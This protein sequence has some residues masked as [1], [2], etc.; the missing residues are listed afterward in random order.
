MELSSSI[1]IIDYYFYIQV[2][3]LKCVIFKI[4]FY[5]CKICINFSL[6]FHTLWLVCPKREINIKGQNKV[7]FDS[8]Y[9]SLQKYRFISKAPVYKGATLLKPYF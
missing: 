5:V 4:F 8:R 6:R 3:Y 7:R 1:E 2:Y 9:S